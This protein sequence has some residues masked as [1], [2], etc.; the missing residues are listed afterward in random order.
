LKGNPQMNIVVAE[1]RFACS[2]ALEGSHRKVLYE[3]KIIAG[4]ES[5]RNGQAGFTP[6]PM[7]EQVFLA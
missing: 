1:S 6:L 4:Q 3:K 5:R 7:Q 2:R